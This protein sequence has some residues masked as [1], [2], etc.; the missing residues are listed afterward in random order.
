[1]VNVMMGIKDIYRRLSGGKSRDDEASKES[2]HVPFVLYEADEEEQTSLVT[3]A[4]IY[5][6]VSRL[7]DTL[8]LRLLN[9]CPVDSSYGACTGFSCEFFED[10]PV[11]EVAVYFEED[12][13]RVKYVAD[14]CTPEEVCRMLCAYFLR[15]EVPEIDGRWEK[16][17]FYP[18]PDDREPYWLYVGYSCFRHISYDDVM[19]ALSDLE[20][21]KCQS[22]LLRTPS[23]SNGYMEVGGSLGS[24]TVKAAVATPSG[25]IAVY[26][27]CTSHASL[28]KDWLSGYYHKYE[29]P[30]IRDGWE[31][32]TDD[33]R[34]RVNNNS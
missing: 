34:S 23:G 33:E 16:Q 9:C 21:G 7:S 1:M 18:E 20:D 5:D 14:F 11:Y 19:A 3:S 15:Q 32:I 26:R 30:P 12:S 2:V 17:Y 27:T 24:Y 31:D 10:I 4:K 13:Q 6:A 28:I 29:Y 8:N 22:F 25:D